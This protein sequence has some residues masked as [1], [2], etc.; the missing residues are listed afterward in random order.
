M[1]RAFLLVL[2]CVA[3]SWARCTQSGTGFQ[4]IPHSTCNISSGVSNCA[5]IVGSVNLGCSGCASVTA[6]PNGGYPYYCVLTSA[7]SVRCNYYPTD[8]FAQISYL[9][10]DTKAEADS[11]N[12]ALHPTASGCVSCDTVVV[13]D[14]KNEYVV[15]LG[16]GGY[17]KKKN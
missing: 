6:T 14:C 16:A 12:C 5:E 17:N 1:I 11:V 2:F 13:D 8:D 10:C 4:V 7:S 15:N 9:M 3:V